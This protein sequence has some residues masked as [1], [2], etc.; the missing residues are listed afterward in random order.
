MVYWGR[1]GIRDLTGNKIHISIA[2]ES[3]A[4]FRVREK[5]VEAEIVNTNSGDRGDT[6]PRQE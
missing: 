5:A 2:P 4:A 1:G 3:L 6:E